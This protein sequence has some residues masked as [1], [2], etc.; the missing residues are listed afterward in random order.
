MQPTTHASILFHSFSNAF[1][2]HSATGLRTRSAIH[3]TKNLFIIL[4]CFG[5]KPCCNTTTVGPV[6][7]G[8]AT[9]PVPIS[10]YLR[11]YT[12][13]VFTRNFYLIFK[14]LMAMSSVIF[15]VVKPCNFCRWLPKLRRKVWPP[16]LQTS[17][18]WISNNKHLNGGKN[19]HILKTRNPTYQGSHAAQFLLFATDTS[20]LTIEVIYSSE[21]LVTIDRTIWPHNPEAHYR[22]RSFTL[23]HLLIAQRFLNK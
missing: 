15:W 5:R 9:G 14:V 23:P 20:T 19:T 8:P 21:I 16:S 6:V 11:F 4:L 7:V 12:K 22:Q 17:R 3:L 13:D 18:P 10:N 2:L 1:F